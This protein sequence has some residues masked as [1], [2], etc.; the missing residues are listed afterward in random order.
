[1]RRPI[2]LVVAAAAAVAA[3]AAAQTPV[4]SGTTPPSTTTPPPVAPPVPPV[5]QVPAPGALSIVLKKVT[6]SPAA[7]LSG[8]RVRVEGTVAPYVA[9]QQV[10][11]RLYRGTTKVVS[12]R[13]AVRPGSDG[14][15]GTFLLGLRTTGR[16]HLVVR[17]SHRATAEQA[18]MVAKAHGLDV[19]PRSVA[20]GARGAGVRLLQSRLRRLGYVVG[21]RGLY[22]ARTARAVLAFRKVTGLARTETATSDMMRRLVRG[23]GRFKI[24]FPKHGKHV[25]ADLSLQVMALIKGGKVDRIYPISSGKPSTP[26]VLG[27]FRVYSKT[28]G[29]NAKGMVFTSYFHGGYGIHGY[30]EVPVYAASHGCLREPVPDAVSIF[31]WISYGDLVDVYT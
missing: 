21:A 16:G 7:V 9:G 13:V 8:D 18:T 22:D 28:P 25:E 17:A 10:V 1:M 20:P 12:R 30:A 4:P 5:P 3:P 29:T 31:R 2:A 11:V 27:T 24:R 26:T 19:L 23:A 14:A 6:G 15:T